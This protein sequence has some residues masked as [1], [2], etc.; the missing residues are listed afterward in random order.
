MKPVPL[1]FAEDRH[2]AIWGHERWLV[3]AH[4]SA[5]SVVS[6]GPFAGRR[7]DDLC[8]TL[9]TDLTG[10]LARGN[11]PLLIKDIV[12]KCRLSMQVHPNEVTC[13]TTGGEPKSELWHVLDAESGGV[14]FAGVRT[15]VTRQDLEK[16]ISDGCIEDV[17]LR[18]DAVVGENVFVP[19][20]LVHAIGGGVRV[21]EVQQSS[22]TTYRLYDWG[23][24]DAEGRP[25]QLH[26]SEG[27]AAADL[28]ATPVISR[29]DFACPYFKVCVLSPHAEMDVPA[30]PG[31]FRV[32]V[33]AQGGF[34]LESDA[35]RQ[36]IATGCA[37]LVPAVV[38]ATVI[39]FGDDIRL[40]EVSMRFMR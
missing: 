19:G 15:G 18:H 40:L 32:L 13:R 11:F 28:N 14:L 25:R 5:P 30:D 9:G 21:L 38:A 27:L 39:P 12:A 29:G 34:A 35:G 31:T 3:S 10:T 17:V 16:A 20:G 22:D 26:V 1:T 33:A 7:L 4:P 37:V 24:V 36:E 6:G 8:E 23:R 2:V